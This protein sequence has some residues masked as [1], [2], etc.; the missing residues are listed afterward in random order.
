MTLRVSVIR[1]KGHAW[2]R[3]LERTLYPPESG[4]E[5]T[6]RALPLVQVRMAAWGALSGPSAISPAG[7]V[8]GSAGVSGFL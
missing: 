3:G 5:G 8:R 1:C 2:T 4:V 7:G 6:G